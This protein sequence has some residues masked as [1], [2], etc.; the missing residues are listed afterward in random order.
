MFNAETG[1][2]FNKLLVYEFSVIVGY[3]GVRHAIAAYDIFPDEL[4]NLLSCD[5]G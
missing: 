2:E 3:D 5:S 4:L 1:V